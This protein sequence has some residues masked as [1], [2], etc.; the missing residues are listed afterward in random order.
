MEKNELRKKI[1]LLKKQYSFNQLNEF[2]RIAVLKVL[3]SKY[4]KNSKCVL[5]YYPLPDEI[6]VRELIIKG[7][8]SGKTI[9]L[10]KVTKE[11]MVLKVYE[12]ENSLKKGAFNILEPSGED[13]FEEDYYK[14]DLAIIPGMAFDKDFN[15]LGRGKGYYDKFLKKIPHA[16]K[17]G[18][19]FPFQF[20]EALPM[21]PHDEKMSNVVF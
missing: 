19:C 13:F 20:L 15:R 8:L 2:S 4:W 21:E 6:D 14:I 17:I 3:N 10:P 5:L 12:D 16:K 18:I 11:D 1:R 9:L 7:K